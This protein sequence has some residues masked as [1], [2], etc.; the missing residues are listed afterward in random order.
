M[1]AAIGDE[2]NGEDNKSASDEHI[3][4]ETGAGDLNKD[5]V[6][7]DNQSTLNQFIN[8]KYL[9][10]IHTVKNPVMV[11]CN[12]GS[13]T[14][15]QK[16]MFRNFSVWYNPHGTTNILSLKTVTNHNLVT[17]K[18]NDRGGVFTI[19]TPKRNIKFIQHPCGLHYLDLT[20]TPFLHILMVMTM[21]ENYEGYTK[22]QIDGAIRTRCIYGMMDDPSQH[23]FKNLVHDRM[24]QNCPVTHH[25]VMNESLDYDRQRKCQW[26][27]RLQ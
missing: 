11:Y 4:H 5:W 3:F 2:T 18:S 20:K 27:E 21:K 12:A 8:P 9:T 15:N 10:N 24:I 7:L 26:T 16:G 14:T 23:D 25:D 1:N 6:L 19:H 17:Y 13:T 22:N